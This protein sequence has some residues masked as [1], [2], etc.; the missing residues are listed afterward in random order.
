ML[1]A[2]RR[3]DLPL[4]LLVLAMGV[5][6]A[7]FVDAESESPTIG[8]LEPPPEAPDPVDDFL[9]DFDPIFIDCFGGTEP[10]EAE[11]LD[12]A[13]QEAL[14]E[15]VSA[16][17]EELRE[18]RF[19]KPVDARFL[20]ADEL[21][22]EV[23]GL[24]GEELKPAE[25]RGEEEL[26]KALGAIPD[27]GDLAE[28]TTEALGG[29]VAGL[30]DTRSEE[31]LV[32][33]AEEVGADEV[34]TLAHEL[35]HALSDQAL[36]ILDDI[37]GP[38]AADR[39]LA[40]AALVEGDATLLMELYALSYVGLDEQLALGESVPGAEEFEALPDYVQRSLLFPYLEGLRFVCYRLAD[41][42]FRALDRTYDDPPKAT[43]QVIF[44]DRYG[45]IEPI[46]VRPVRDPGPG[47]ASVT[48]RELGAAELEWLLQ[49]PGGDPAAALPETRRL[50][51]GW[52]G[53]AAELW[54]RGNERA[55]SI[56]MLELPGTNSLCGAVGAWYRAA[57]PEAEVTAG[58]GGVELTFTEPGRVGV[59]SCAG[60]TVK[61]GVAP[62][63]AEASSLA[64]GLSTLIG[65]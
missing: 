50:V 24:V 27:D 25:V 18:L 22:T 34:I 44:P 1:A 55:L 43:S 16:R 17:V 21:R 52:A 28:I 49:A 9:A 61:L 42:G 14:V 11:E 33:T 65:R 36:G 56:S 2:V 12:T 13:D 4:I 38:E 19:S 29:Q 39:E 7:L 63:L 37:G 53:G 35:E 3:P 5:A 41:G 60:V 62:D 46:R 30:Y 10:T 64:T 47:W 57:W 31:L 45:V 54:R 20:E 15:E 51:F 40:Y 26:L 6:L 32:L 48:R 23:E 58:T 8:A 59:L